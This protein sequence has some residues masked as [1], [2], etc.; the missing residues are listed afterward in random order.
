MTAWY[1][2]CATTHPFLW[3]AAKQP[4]ARWHADGDGP[5]HYLADT[6]TGAWAEFLRHEEIVDADDLEGIDRALWVVD[7]PSDVVVGAP[8]P[9]LD[10]DVLIGDETTYKTCRVEAQALRTAGATALVTRSAALVPDGATGWEVGPGGETSSVAQDGEVLVIFGPPTGLVGWP[11]C[12]PGKPDPRLIPL[13]R[14]L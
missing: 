11:A 4:A 14:P 3:T 10:P 8:S 9:S 2:T 13:V 12:L 1:R 6:P 5:A 7:V